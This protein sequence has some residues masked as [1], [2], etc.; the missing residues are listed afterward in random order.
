[1]QFDKIYEDLLVGGFPVRSCKTLVLNSSVKSFYVVERTIE[2]IHVGVISIALITPSS[3]TVK[4]ERV[5][6][7]F[8]NFKNFD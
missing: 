3:K 2:N 7:S 6:F 4:T 5:L 1:M 8:P